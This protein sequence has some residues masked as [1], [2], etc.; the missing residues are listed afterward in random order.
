MTKNN[1]KKR[2]P[3]TVCETDN[4]TNLNIESCTWKLESTNKSLDF[5]PNELTLKS[6]HFVWYTTLRTSLTGLGIV[7]EGRWDDELWESKD[8]PSTDDPELEEMGEWGSPSTIL[9]T[10]LPEEISTSRYES[11]DSFFLQFGRFV[12]VLPN[13]VDNHS[14]CNLL[15][16]TAQ[17]TSSQM[18]PA[19]LKLK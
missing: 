10:A 8:D 18:K 15:A 2:V 12:Q 5:S 13:S 6:A 1:V 3:W 11:W 7:I 19:Q 4:I 17:R 14:R 9:R 16:E